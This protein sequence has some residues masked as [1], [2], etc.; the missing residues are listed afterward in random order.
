MSRFD[1]C[2]VGL[3]YIGLP[4][5]A[6]CAGKGM[7]VLGVDIKP[8]VVEIVKAGKIH[9]EEP[10]LEAAVSAAVEGGC[11]TAATDLS[12]AD[13]YMIAVPTPFVEES[14]QPDMSMVRQAAEAIAEVVEE[15]ALVILQSTSPVHATRDHVQQ[16]IEEKRPDLAGKLA[17]VYCPERAIP[18]KTMVEMVENDRAVGGLTEEA[19]QQGLAFYQKF[20]TGDLLPTQAA[21]AEMVKLV[22]NASR[23]GQIAFANALS[24]VCD[25]MELDVWDVIRLANRHPRVNILQPG[26]GV[27]GHCIAVDPWF[28]ISAAPEEAAFLKAARAVNDSKPGW[29]VG[30]VKEAVAGLE[31]PTV[32]V[33]GLA[34]KEN[35]D[36]FRESP[37]VVITDRLMDEKVG[38][39]LVVEPFM[40]NS[41]VYDLVT[42]E[43]GLQKA[44]VV[45]ML[46]AH[47]VFK[48]I[49]LG[50]LEGKKV[51]DTRGVLPK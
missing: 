47:D 2:V 10:G 40:K 22:E 25:K 48:E 34:Y 8:E 16:V 4:T 32:C 33:L 3:G 28:I 18:G 37:S 15:R 26:P 17:Y 41:T 9:L 29:V 12:E 19:T 31:N 24:F 5:A 30:K 27:G 51:I 21:T 35:V 1:L 42:L 46:T 36:D 39:V 6:I 20:V 23:D 45:V 43:E 7:K 38:H 13:I 14:K 11:L 50:Q 49:T 44:D